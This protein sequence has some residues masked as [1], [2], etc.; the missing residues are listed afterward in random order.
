GLPGAAPGA[1]FGAGGGPRVVAGERVGE[2]LAEETD[3]LAFSYCRVQYSTRSAPCQQPRT[4]NA[5][6]GFQAGIRPT[7]GG[8]RHTAGDRGGAR[9]GVYDRARVAP[10]PGLRIL[11]GA[12]ARVGA[13]A[14]A[15]RTEAGEHAPAARRPARAT[16]GRGGRQE[17]SNRGRCMMSARRSAFGAAILAALVLVVGG[18]WWLRSPTATGTW[19]RE[20]APHLF[21]FTA[22]ED[23]AGRVSGLGVLSPEEG[24]GAP[25]TV[26]GLRVGR[27]VTLTL[28][29]WRDTLTFAG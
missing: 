4:R 26:R 28:E 9:R 22:R 18:A 14:R 29:V 20:S 27:D 21:H 17:G 8:G 2:L 24:Q 19:R 3:T 23:D 13:Q 25:V 16:G 7:H 1:I 5:N 6:D 11:P 10:G 15:P 12:P